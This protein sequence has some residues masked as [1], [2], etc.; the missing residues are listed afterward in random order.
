[1]CRSVYNVNFGGFDGN[2]C[3]FN[4]VGDGGIC[5]QMFAMEF[6]GCNDGVGNDGAA[7]CV[8]GGGVLVLVVIFV[9]VLVCN[10]AGGR[11][12]WRAAAK[13]VNR[14]NR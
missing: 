4:G 6:G 1:M 8:D 12:R 5:E 7:W 2:L 3:S 10:C 13:I 9:G 11:A 14:M